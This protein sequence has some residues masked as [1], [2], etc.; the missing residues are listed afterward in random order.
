MPS[1]QHFIWYRPSTLEAPCP[2][3]MPLLGPAGPWRVAELALDSGPLRRPGQSQSLS[4][5]T[6]VELR[7]LGGQRITGGWN[8]CRSEL[9][10]GAQG[11]CFGGWK[12]PEPTFPGGVTAVMPLRGMRAAEGK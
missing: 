3:D 6:V 11:A 4:L 12:P 7:S 5:R 1:S 10:S 8:R 9:I 2:W